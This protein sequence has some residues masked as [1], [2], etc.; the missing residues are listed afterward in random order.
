M[1]P[2]NYRYQS[3]FARKHYGEGLARG[4]AEGRVEGR[5][6]GRSKGKREILIQLLSLRF[7]PLDESALSWMEVASD[8]ELEE[9]ADR[10]LS[11]PSLEDTLGV[12]SDHTQAN[13]Q[14]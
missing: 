13:I 10:L 5:A 9:I 11:A 4:R 1:R 2:A 12:T 3:E 8:V 6:E 7:G 14:E